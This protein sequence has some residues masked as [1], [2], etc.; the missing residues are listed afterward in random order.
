MKKLSLL[1]FGLPQVTSLVLM[2]LMLGIG[3]E[4]L[5]ALSPNY[6][7]QMSKLSSDKWVK[8]KTTGEGIHQITYE[9]LR[10]WGFDE[11]EK[12]NVYG[13]GATLL[14]RDIFS[15]SD[16]DDVKLTYT[17]HQGE[18]LYFYSTADVSVNLIE[19]TLVTSMRNN[20][21]T[22][23]YYLLSDREVS[24]EEQLSSAKFIAEAETDEE[25][26]AHLSVYFNE[27]NISNP[28][29]MGGYF[30]GQEFKPDGV[31]IPFTIKNIGYGKTKWKKFTARVSFGC[32]SSSLTNN[33]KVSI[34][35]P[36]PTP[37][38]SQVAASGVYDGKIKYKLGSTTLKVDIS[39]KPISNGSYYLT[40]T[41]NSSVSYAALDTVWFIYPRLNK[42]DNDAQLSMYFP[43]TQIGGVFT[44][45]ASPTTHVVN[46][47]DMANI[48]EYELV[49]ADEGLYKG[50]FDKD[51]LSGK[52]GCH[53]VAYDTEKEHPGV[54][55]VS[56]VANQN[57]HSVSTP[58][59]VIITTAELYDMAEGLAEL[60]RQK[61]GMDVLV[62][63]HTKLF[64]EF[65]SATPDAMA[66]RRFIKMLYDRDPSKFKYVILYGP[67]HWDN[68][69]VIVDKKDR[70]LVYETLSPEY[71]A[72]ET[73]AFGTDCYFGML[74]DDYDPQ[75]I[76]S[77][78]IDVR[79]GRISAT[80]P[81]QALVMN[82]KIE[83]YMGNPPVAVY[84]TAI[85]M[86]DD[87]DKCMHLNQSEQLADAFQNLHKAAT[88]IRA[89]NSNFQWKNNKDA[90][91]LRSVVIKAL[92]E[93]AGMFTYVG[94]GS[95]EAFGGENLWSRSLA[96]Q[97]T[98]SRPT[99]GVF[100]T[101]TA[102]GYD[103][104]KDGVGQEMLFKENGGAVALI[105]SGR[106][107]YAD[108]NQHIA[109][110]VVEEYATAPGDATI[111]DIWMRARN[112]AIKSGLE[113]SRVNTMCYNLGGDPALRLF[114]PSYS[115]E[116]TS[117]SNTETIF[118]LEQVQ[119]EGQVLKTGGELAEDFN[120]TVTLRLYDAPYQVDILQRKSDDVQQSGGKAMI[121]LDQDILVSKTVPVIGGKFSISFMSPVP[122]HENDKQ[123]NRIVFLADAEDGRSADGIFTGNIFV[124]G[125][126]EPSEDPLPG[127]APIID[128]LA[129]NEDGAT[130][131]ATISGDVC[132]VASGTISQAGIN[133]SAS[134]IGAVSTLVIDNKKN[135]A[136]ISAAI[137][138]VADDTWT[139][140]IPVTGLAQ[141]PHCATLTIADNAGRRTS[142]TINFTLDSNN[143]IILTADVATVRDR[144]TF[145]V[146]H[147]FGNVT[148]S[149]LV[150]ED[151]M[152]NEIA[153][154][155]DPAFPCTVSFK[156][157][158]RLSPVRDGIY[159]AYVQMEGDAGR[160]NSPR[161]PIVLIN[162][163]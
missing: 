10:Q 31:N 45:E 49:G 100:A 42:M 75:N 37:I 137:K 2:A 32:A 33:L 78:P 154:R 11:P 59:M 108:L 147:P 21:S 120:G 14:S 43:E 145:D 94:H 88:P 107:V 140:R 156:Q 93:G 86:S 13:Y 97:T 125:S 34:S 73:R 104:G 163:K 138:Q 159:Q 23:V 27:D 96:A 87:G 9:Q 123:R 50:M 136:G 61:D 98:Y 121:T 110:P 41:L 79:V 128:Y 7:T 51:I 46:V 99:I 101:C 109:L 66:Y 105:T 74:S 82:R 129:A 142:Q 69:Q 3:T 22:E 135:I 53:L 1:S 62:V 77:T 115:I 30:L 116:V 65:S 158:N 81:A 26:D 36:F 68:R 28:T 91:D 84:N 35:S 127:S 83:A 8:I 146:E 132:I 67:S 52:S 39:D 20:Y 131:G 48:Y 76:I 89:H 90:Q 19:S 155:Q 58:D 92:E 106:T 134:S 25:Y 85:F 80:S 103:L 95:D 113:N 47:S 122:V 149:R 111:G 152:G 18:K 150:I 71:S 56:A 6:Y 12:V 118:P 16:P 63:E 38:I 133:T 124:K 139:L 55:M 64:N 29:R 153:V 15:E 44:L 157:I 144:V 102:Y 151:R 72:D 112:R 54:E 70:L 141:G 161:I 40:G 117:A 4:S 148:S 17:N 24:T 5:L 126:A 130:D 162:K 160:G 143:S 119:M 114:A 57:F 60:H